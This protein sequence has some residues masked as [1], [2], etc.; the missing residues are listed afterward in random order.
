MFMFKVTES[1]HGKVECFQTEQLKWGG[2]GRKKIKEEK[3][4]KGCKTK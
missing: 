1:T 2:R 3:K 4:K